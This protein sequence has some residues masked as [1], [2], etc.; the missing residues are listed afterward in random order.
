M[1]IE[2]T[3]KFREVY[4]SQNKNIRLGSYKLSQNEITS[5]INF[6][7]VEELIRYSSPSLGYYSF[8]SILDSNILQVSLIPPNSDISVELYKSIIIFYTDLETNEEDIAFVIS[9]QGSEKL[10]RATNLIN[11]KNF[12]PICQV[13][14]N[15]SKD[16]ERLEGRGQGRYTDIWSIEEEDNLYYITLDSYIEYNQLEKSKD[17]TKHLDTT[18][19]DEYGLKIY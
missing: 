15:Q 2:Y 18:Y 6:T 5:D 8:S 7:S 16:T 17:N 12:N 4:N 9:L 3:E 14:Y 13:E 1:I 11:I 10:R 19:I